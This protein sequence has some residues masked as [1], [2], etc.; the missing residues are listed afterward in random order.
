MSESDEHDL[1]PFSPQEQQGRVVHGEYVFSKRAINEATQ[2]GPSIGP[3]FKKEAIKPLD[4]TKLSTFLAMPCGSNL[5]WQT[6]RSLMNTV[7]ACMH[8]DI[9]LEVAMV[10]ESSI[11]TLARSRA[12]HGFLEAEDYSRIFWIDSDI[13]WTPDDFMRVLQLSHH[14]EIVCAGYPMRQ[15]DRPNSYIVQH[16]DMKNFEVNGAG[17]VKIDGTGLGF[18]CIQRRVIDQFVKTKVLL[19]DQVNKVDSMYDAFRIDAFE[20]HVRGE[21]AAFFAD[22]RELGYDIWLD[23]CINLGHV[24]QKVYRG[25]MVEALGLQHAYGLKE[26]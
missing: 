9:K 11:V 21:D 17:L 25:N 6:V 24:G 7:R 8:N 1:T 4:V 10:A 23:P 3:H 12:L 20:G 22:L 19:Q 16:P 2:A 18:T 13:V 14:Y 5:P 26:K 15:S